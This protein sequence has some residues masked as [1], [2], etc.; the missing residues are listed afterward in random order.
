MELQ[1]DE[2]FDCLVQ[3][4]FLG[5]ARRSVE[6]IEA[7]HPHTRGRLGLVVGDITAPRLGLQA[8][9]AKTLARRVTQTWHLAAVYDL[10][11]A[12][13]VGL[14]I[15]VEGTRNVLELLADAPD[16]EQLHY[17]STAYVSGTAVGDFLETDLDVGQGFKNF[18]EE[19]KFLAEVE[20]IKSGLPAAVYRPGVVVGDSRTGETAKFDGPYFALR[21]MTRLPSPGVFMKVGSGHR[22][23]NLV[24][25]DFVVEALAQLARS[26]ASVGQTFHLTDPNPPT[27]FAVEELF[28]KAL[29]KSFVFVPVPT[30]LAKVFFTPGPMQRVF[31]M[32][33][34][35]VDYFDHPV[36]YDCSL[37]T[38]ALADSGVRCPRFQDYAQRLVAFYREKRATVRREAMI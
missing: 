3:E 30:A 8:A 33:V 23:I 18:Y 34:Q 36:R 15:N 35:T 26:E 7:L 27:V 31:G 32:P 10:A 1:P 12:R 9:E 14:R 20:V 2:R 19:T 11:V 37:A 28:A 16:F 24:P 5:V 17:V 38:Q 29:G 13:R 4:K 22:T 25:V 21:A 6:E